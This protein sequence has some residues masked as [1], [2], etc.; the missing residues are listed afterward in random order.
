MKTWQALRSARRMNIALYKLSKNEN[1]TSQSEI[2]LSIG[3]GIYIR[4]KVVD[5]DKHVITVHNKQGAHTIRREFAVSIS[6]L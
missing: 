1:E 6:A 4:G 5:F 2:L 3:E